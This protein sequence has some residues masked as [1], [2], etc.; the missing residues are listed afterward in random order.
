MKNVKAYRKIL[1]RLLPKTGQSTVYIANDDATYQSGWW[2]GKLLLNNKVRFIPKTIIGDD[3]VL[4]RATG[5]TWAADGNE[6]GCN[7]GSSRNWADSIAFAAG[8]SFAGYNDWRL[9]NIKELMSI[10]DYGHNNPAID[11]TYFVNMHNDNYWSS[12]TYTGLSTVAFRKYMLNGEII[13][14]LKTITIKLCCV[15]GG[16]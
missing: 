11:E 12:T 2:R 10:T 3:V 5:L 14:M 15:R 13:G 1:S 6:L 8:L 9:P 16:L 4:D 7:N